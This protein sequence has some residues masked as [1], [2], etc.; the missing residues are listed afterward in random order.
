MLAL[1]FEEMFADFFNL[2]LD[3][4]IVPFINVDHK[5]IMIKTSSSSPTT[6][7]PPGTFVEVELFANPH[8]S[9]EFIR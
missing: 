3:V 4:Q 8:N 6:T 5:K 1:A 9:Q 7:T 2:I